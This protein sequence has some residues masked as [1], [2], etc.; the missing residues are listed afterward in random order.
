[1]TREQMV[2]MLYRFA[3]SPEVAATGF[4]QFTDGASVSDW[5]VD[6]MAWALNNGVITGMGD[7]ILSPSGSATRAQA[8]AMLMRFVEA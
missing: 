7:G 8:A 3:N 4:G 6:A 5:A 1:I 2:T